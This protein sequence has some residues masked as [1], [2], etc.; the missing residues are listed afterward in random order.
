MVAVEVGA[1]DL[2]RLSA[3]GDSL[4]LVVKRRKQ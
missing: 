2:G 1:V 4:V 3:V